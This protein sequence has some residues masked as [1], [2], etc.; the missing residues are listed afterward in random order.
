MPT[1]ESCSNMAGCG[2]KD[3]KCI[4]FTQCSDFIVSKPERC[5]VLRGE[6]DE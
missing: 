6:D 5:N 4:T 1:E 3:N 2:W